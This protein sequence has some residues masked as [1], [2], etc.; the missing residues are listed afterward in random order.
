MTGYFLWGPPEEGRGTVV[1]IGIDERFIE[2][3]FER[4][5]VADTFRCTFCPPVVDELP[6]LVATSPRRPW[7]ELWPAIGRLD[8]RRTRM[9][10]AQQ[11]RE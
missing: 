2:D 1:S 4:V 5:R 11:E 9:L 6:I 8:D 3:N 10:R 7:S